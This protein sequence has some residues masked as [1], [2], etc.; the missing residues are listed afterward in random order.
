MTMGGVER[1]TFV[2]AFANGVRLRVLE[3]TSSPRL[4][5][6]ENYFREYAEGRVT[7]NSHYALDWLPPPSECACP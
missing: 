2:V 3:T 1:Q 7:K 4:P 5:D 6:L